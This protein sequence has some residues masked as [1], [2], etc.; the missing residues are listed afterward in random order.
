MV[1][2][3]QL[4]AFAK[5]QNCEL[6]RMNFN[7]CE[8]KIKKN[9]KSNSEDPNSRSSLVAQGDKDLALSLWLEL[10]GP[11]P[12]KK[13]KKIPGSSC[14]GSAGYEPNQYPCGFDPWPRSVD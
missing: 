6:K 8:L 13:K 4:S 9:F 2:V 7:V 14:C 3:T 10:L 1:R 12:K 11:E 5:T